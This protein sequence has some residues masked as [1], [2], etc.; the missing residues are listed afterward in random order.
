MMN[1][2]F[3]SL[4]RPLQ[5]RKHLGTQTTS[6]PSN[7]DVIALPRSRTRSKH[8]HPMTPTEVSSACLEGE[9]NCYMYRKSSDRST[10]YTV[11]IL[12]P[13]RSD[14]MSFNPR[15]ACGVSDDT[16]LQVIKVT[17]TGTSGE[18]IG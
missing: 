3:Y 11:L 10:E 9:L 12:A 1:K 17:I 16:V 18:D 14:N 4:S 6:F 13:S 15:I 7:R 2:V 8:T 5:T